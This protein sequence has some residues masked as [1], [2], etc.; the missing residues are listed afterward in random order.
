[1]FLAGR[2]PVEIEPDPL[3]EPS[4]EAD[5]WGSGDDLRTVPLIAVM[6]P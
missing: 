3:A 2:G 4:D 5:E 1:M 6:A